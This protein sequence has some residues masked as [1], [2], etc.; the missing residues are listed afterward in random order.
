[1]LVVA[2]MARC[3]IKPLVAI[4]E[5]M[6]KGGRIMALGE[7]PFRDTIYEVDGRSVGLNEYLQKSA[8]KRTEWV[9]FAKTDP[10]RWIRNTDAEKRPSTI[11]IEEG[12]DPGSKGMRLSIRNLDERVGSWDMFANPDTGSGTPENAQA[13]ELCVKGDAGTAHVSVEL[14]ERDGSRWFATIPLTTEWQRHALSRTAFSFWLYGSPPSRGKPGDTVS[15]QSLSRVSIGLADSYKP[16][17]KK[18]PLHEIWVSG[19]NLLS[20]KPEVDSRLA[21]FPMGGLASGKPIIEGISPS[22]KTYPINHRAT[23]RFNG[24]RSD[25]EP[26]PVIQPR[27]ARS[28]FVRPG[29]AGFRN[30][31]LWRFIPVV[32]TC[33]ANGVITGA[34]IS[35]I[36]DRRDPVHPQWICPVATDDPDFYQQHGMIGLL[37]DLAEEAVRGVFLYEGGA[38]HSVSWGNEE[39]PVGAKVINFSGKQTKV[40]VEIAVRDAAG[41]TVFREVYPLT[42]EAGEDGDVS[43]VWE[44]GDLPGAAFGVET[45]LLRDGKRM[46][47][48]RQPLRVW[49]KQ[50]RPEFVR[51]ADGQFQLNG[52]RWFLHGLNYMPSSGSAR[53]DEGFSNWL[54]RSAYDSEITRRDLADVKDLGLNAVSVFIEA[55][56]ASDARNLN[57]LLLTC[58]ELGLRVNLNVRPMFDRAVLKKTIEGFRLAE[59]DTIFAYDVAWEPNW[60]NQANRRQHDGAWTQWVTAKYGTIGKAEEA[61]KMPFPRDAGGSR[62]TNPPDSMFA[63]EGPW[64]A[65]A[66]D[67]LQFQ[68]DVLKETYGKL[69]D[70]IR[71]LAPHHHVSLRM[72]SAGTPTA[73]TAFYY[74]YTGLVDAVDFM[75][76]E[77]YNAQGSWENTRPG[78]FNVA[79]SRA[80]APHHPVV[81]TEFGAS[82]WDSDAM[83]QTEALLQAQLRLYENFYR[84]AVDLADADGLI[85]W[86]FPGGLRPFEESD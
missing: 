27:S 73:P 47:R 49:S 14:V 15:L 17:L 25:L 29:G 50:N 30:H 3:E 71:T 46:D 77:A 74:S 78:V 8:V 57:D 35:V 20:L 37:A 66:L 64:Q 61:W 21:A 51:I 45:T 53:E 60:G 40:D 65:L 28:P 32:E 70:F 22:Y 39:M 26:F 4:T 82:V 43:G 42:L 76:P 1:L 62:L 85:C 52:K 11:S 56:K 23:I 36:L 55:D 31:R 24:E 33:D 54:G 44:I 59:E 2:D 7:Q 84:M 13:I 41:K 75:G 68:D 83:S 16:N 63:E 86:Y 81:W 18:N 10:A 58:R 38:E 34:P 5:Y 79:F 12:M 72:A 9:D 69:R 80:V 19:L 6:T 48:I 67:Y